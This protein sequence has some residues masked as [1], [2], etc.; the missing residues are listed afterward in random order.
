MVD[1]VK[2]IELRRLKELQKKAAQHGPNTD[3][4]V[5]IEIQDLLHRYPEQRREDRRLL[6][7]QLDYDFLMNT[8]AAALK[9]LSELEEKYRNDGKK[10]EFRQLIH[11][12]WMITITTML[13][14]TLLLLVYGR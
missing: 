13:F 7:S 2:L 3:P 14:F 5:L 9:R 10:R 12:L 8:V 11:D 6:L 4:A 1:E